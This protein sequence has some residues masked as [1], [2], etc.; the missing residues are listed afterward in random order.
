MH[1]VKKNVSDVDYGMHQETI[2]GR[3]S[4]QQW[5]AFKL[6]SRLTEE[7]RMRQQ[8][9]ESCFVG[10]KLDEAQTQ[11]LLFPTS[12][13]S[14]AEVGRVV[15]PEWQWI[16]KPKEGKVSRTGRP[17]EDAADTVSLE[18]RAAQLP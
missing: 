10:M 7:G 2:A 15:K 16:R 5:Q 8:H 12:P 17:C 3:P 18:R 1:A 13:P 14:D 9:I 6:A 4:T 11:K